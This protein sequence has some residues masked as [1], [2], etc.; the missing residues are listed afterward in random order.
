M[1]VVTFGRMGADLTM[2]K[3]LEVPPEL[4]GQYAGPDRRLYINDRALEAASLPPE[5]RVLDAGCGFG[6]TVFRWH[7]QTGGTFDGLTL[8][9]VQWKLACREARRRGL[10]SNCRFHLRRYYDPIAECYEAVVSI[11]SLIHSQSF[12]D[13]LRNLAQ[14]LKP[15]GKLVLVEDIPL[16]AAE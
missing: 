7:L 4:A 12:P 8:S 9:R 3:A 1:N 6:G 14:A 10:E 16:D 11:E 2:H 15:Q 13:T 5:P